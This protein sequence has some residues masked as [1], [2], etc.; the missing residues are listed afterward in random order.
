M[1]FSLASLDKPR[2]LADLLR[3]LDADLE[4][5]VRRQQD[6]Q[7]GA[8]HAENRP[9]HAKD[10]R[11]TEQGYLARGLASRVDDTRRMIARLGS[12]E[13]VD[14][15]PADPVALTALVAFRDDDP[16]GI[17]T[18]WLVPCAGGIELAQ[19][20]RSV[21]TLTP[22]SPLGRALLGLRTGDEGSV[23][24]PGG[25]RIFEIVSIA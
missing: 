12:L 22:R 13:I 19:R 6:T 17:R 18:A 16:A 21:H 11:A 20:D 4:L 9:E 14:F 5:L 25:E 8:T 10:T 3:H 24:T 7:A 15:G 23:P 1:S 2:L